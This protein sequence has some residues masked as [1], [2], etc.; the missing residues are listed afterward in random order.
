MAKTELNY[1]GMSCPIPIVKL[2]M[3]TRKGATGDVFEITCDDPVFET[4]IKAWCEDTGNT[5]D[6]IAKSGKDIIATITKK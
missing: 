6:N 1:R 4:D 5:L 3:A 2:S